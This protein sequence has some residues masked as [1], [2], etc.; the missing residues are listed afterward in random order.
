[1]VAQA[2]IRFPHEEDDRLH[3]WLKQSRWKLRKLDRCMSTNSTGTSCESADIDFY[4]ARVD[5]RVFERISEYDPKQEHGILARRKCKNTTDWI[6]PSEAFKAL[7]QVDG[8][9]SHLW[10]SGKGKDATTFGQTHRTDSSPSNSRLGKECVDVRGSRRNRLAYAEHYRT[11]V[12]DEC[13]R[14]FPR[15]KECVVLFYFYQPTDPTAKAFFNSLLKQ[16]LASLIE[17]SIPCPAAVQDEID[18]A[19]GLDN[20]QPDVGGLVANILLPLMSKFKEVVVALDGPDICE[21]REQREIW[22]QLQF[23]TE[24]S[25][26]DFR[27]RIVVASQDQSNASVYLPNTNRLRMDTGSNVDDIETLIDH[28]IASRSGRGHLLNDGPLRA[29]VQNFLKENANGM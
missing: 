1:V 23:I 2:L 4:T 18:R 26:A 14:C 27:V 17:M 13:I 28:H 24:S 11:T 29:S 22:T 25:D 15:N 21:P 19:F 6:H 3:A 7:L 16:I 9:I 20:R 5:Y 12:I 8:P 10:I